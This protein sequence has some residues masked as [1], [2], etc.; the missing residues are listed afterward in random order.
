MDYK[1]NYSEKLKHPKWQR[2]RLKILQ[3][4]NFT[5]QLCGDT[6]TE[7]HINHLKYKGEPHEIP[8]RFLETLCK[9]CHALKHST[10]KHYIIFADKI[11]DLYGNNVIVYANQVKDVFFAH[12][13]PNLEFENIIF[14]YTSTDKEYNKNNY[15]A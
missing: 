14:D 6:E 13:N 15:Y 11:K 9:I 2:K 7:L 4:D 10:P 5:C 3:R 1:K 8:N 12:F